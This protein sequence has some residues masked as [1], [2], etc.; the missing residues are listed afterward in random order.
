MESDTIQLELPFTLEDCGGMEGVYLDQAPYRFGYG[1]YSF[2]SFYT[3][4]GIK[5][6]D[7][8]FIKRIKAFNG[9]AKEY[10]ELRWEI[11]SNPHL[12]Q[13]V[14]DNLL[15]NLTNYYGESFVQAD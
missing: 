4:S 9:G 10:Y 14:K 15:W 13:V 11:M 7:S 1:T 8:R 2:R 5:G 3:P 12:H 6:L